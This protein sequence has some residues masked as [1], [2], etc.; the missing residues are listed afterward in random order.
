MVCYKHN[1][2]GL[3][4]FPKHLLVLNGKYVNEFIHYL[5]N[6]MSLLLCAIILIVM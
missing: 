6:L 1:L 2:E 3:E 4:F 5:C